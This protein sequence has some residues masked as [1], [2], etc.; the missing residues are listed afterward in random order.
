[1]KRAGGVLA[2]ATAGA[3]TKWN[4]YLLCDGGDGHP[5][6]LADVEAIKIS[7]PT[8]FLV[9]AAPYLKVVGFAVKV[10]FKVSLGITVP[11]LIDDAGGGVDVSALWNA[12]ADDVTSAAGVEGST[13]VAR[14]AGVA[15]A[16]GA[17]AAMVT[18]VSDRALDELGPILD[19]HAADVR[20]FGLG[21]A[22]LDGRGHVWLCASCTTA[23]AADIERTRSYGGGTTPH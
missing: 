15:G 9:A 6:P 8:R 13:A 11:G 18:T 21:H 19:A 16:K 7:V 12:C 2:R 22:V 23:C 10:A 1:M 17:D 5:H 3:V 4:L 14:V 20:R